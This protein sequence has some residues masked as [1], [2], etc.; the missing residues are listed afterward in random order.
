LTADQFQRR[1]SIVQLDRESLQKSL[2][3]ILSFSKAERLDAHGA[4]A[5]IRFT[6]H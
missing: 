3:F 4:S 6:T 2:P 1:T 5:Q